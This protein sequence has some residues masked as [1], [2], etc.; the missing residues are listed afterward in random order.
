MAGG[1][2]TVPGSG[3]GAAGLAGGD[4]TVPGGGASAIAGGDVTVPGG[5]GVAGGAGENVMSGA[6]AGSATMTGAT[7]TGGDVTVPGGA[8]A[9][10]TAEGSMSGGVG[11][12]PS[13][14]G[15]GLPTSGVSDMSSEVSSRSSQVASGTDAQAAVND[16]GG[17]DGASLM[18]EG[19]AEGVA[20]SHVAGA[21]DLDMQHKV[22]HQAHL[23]GV[24]AGSQVDSVRYGSGLDVNVD[25]EAGHGN[26][27]MDVGQRSAEGKVTAGATAYEDVRYGDPETMARSRVTGGAESAVRDQVPGQATTAAADASYATEAV[28]NPQQVASAEVE[29]AVDRG[30]A[31]QEAKLG[32]RVTPRDPD[33]A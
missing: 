29:G 30:E 14:S 26:D 3:G 22:E 32:V 7:M 8:G 2:V 10:M 17:S 20:G 5:H 9:G 18:R 12:V 31:H 25:R 15:S 24:D 19:G 6:T 28:D 1:D 13:T 16:F 23:G 21:A 27:L 33:K 4:V 11:T